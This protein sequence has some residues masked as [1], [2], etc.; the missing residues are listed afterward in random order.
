MSIVI[1]IIVLVLIALAIFSYLALK[2]ALS[3]PTPEMKK[4]YKELKF[5]STIVL[6]QII[7]GVYVWVNYFA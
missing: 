2:Q 7:G 3:D 4:E 6:C 1:T 5:W